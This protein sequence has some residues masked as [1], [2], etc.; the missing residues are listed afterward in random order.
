[1]S[2]QSKDVISCNVLTQ[3]QGFREGRDTNGIAQLLLL[4]PQ[5]SGLSNFTS[6]ESWQTMALLSKSG[7]T[8]PGQLTGRLFMPEKQ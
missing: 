5:G 3:S 4:T 8:L 6:Q 7:S 2:A 1:M